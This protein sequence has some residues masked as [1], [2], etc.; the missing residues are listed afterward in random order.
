[1]AEGPITSASP[2]VTVRLH[3]GV[4]AAARRIATG[5]P[6]LTLE[7]IACLAISMMEGA[8]TSGAATSAAITEWMERQMMGEATA[9]V[10]PP[11][12]AHLAPWEG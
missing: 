7:H 4:Q 12:S 6:H 11:A 1:M 5:R 2:D 8:I 3:W 9:P 10:S